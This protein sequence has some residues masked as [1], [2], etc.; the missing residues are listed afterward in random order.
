[1]TQPSPT[2]PDAGP[3]DRVVSDDEIFE[4]MKLEGNASDGLSVANIGPE[5]RVLMLER[6]T[7]FDDAFFEG[8]PGDPTKEGA[9]RKVRAAFGEFSYSNI[10]QETQPVFLDL[11]DALKDTEEAKILGERRVSGVVMMIDIDQGN[12]YR[13]G[14]ITIRGNDDTKTSVIRRELR[15]YPGEPFN[16]DHIAR[17]KRNLQRTQWFDASAPGGGISIVPRYRTTLSDE[18]Q[19]YYDVDIYVDV[20]EGSTGSINASAGF[21]PGSG[22]TATLSVTKRNFDL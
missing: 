8:D 17:A 10:G 7:S 14:E 19:D 1:M 2:A 4:A 20:L 15:I 13:V 21:S 16:I 3:V 22:A 5:Y 9:L 11:K 6:F 12:K 18:S